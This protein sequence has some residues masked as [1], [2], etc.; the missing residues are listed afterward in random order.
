RTLEVGPHAKPFKLFKFEM[1]ASNDILR[2]VV[3]GGGKAE[4]LE[5]LTKPGPARWSPLETR[6]VIGREKGPYVVDTL[7]VP[8]ENP[9][10]ALMFLSGVDFFRNGDAAVCTIHGDVW[11]VRGIDEKLENLRGKR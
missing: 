9:W 10:K 4:D 5:P 3:G 11:M 1:P 6:G 7:A 8:Y 2:M